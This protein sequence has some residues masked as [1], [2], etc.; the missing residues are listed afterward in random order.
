MTNLFYRNPRLLILSLALI[1]V[2]GLSSYMILPRMEDPLLTD[3]VA[4]INTIYP[5]ADAERVEALVTEKIEES[6]REIDEIKEVRSSSRTGISTI[7]IELRDNVYETAGIWSRIRDKIDDVNA[8]LP[9]GVLEPEFDQV[10]VKAFA[11]IVSLTWKQDDQPNFAILRRLSKELQDTMETIPGTQE[12]E[13]FGDPNEEVVVNLDPS[14]LASLNM[15]VQDVSRQLEAS[16]AKV[17]AGQLRGARADL[18]LEVS[19]EFDSLDRIG[20][21][22]IRHGNGSQFVQLSDIAQLDKRIQEPASSVAILDGSRG[23]A[24]GALVRS[25]YRIDHWTTDANKTLEQFAKTLPKGVELDIVFE[26]NRYVATRLFQLLVNLVLGGLA[27]AAVVFF[28]MGW[29]S[30]LVVGTALPLASLMVLAGMRFMGIPVHQM[31]VT[32]LIIALGLL[33]DN[34]IVVVDEVNARLR[35]GMKAPDAVAKSVKHLFVPLLGST[36]T[37]ALAF[38]P[39]ALMPGPAGEFVGSIAISV[40]MAIVSSFVLAMTIL[41]AITAITS[42]L[43]NTRPDN[44]WLRIWRE[45]FSTPKLTRWYRASLDFVYQRPLVG[46]GIGLVL[47]VLGAIAGFQLP[48]QFFPPADRDQIYVELELPAQSSMADTLT[49]MSQLRERLEVNDRVQ[50]V[51]WFAGESAPTFYYNVI[52]RRRNVS[53]YAQ[54]LVQLDSAVGVREV[55]HQLQAELDLAVPSGRV[56]VRQLEQGPPFD[57]PVE[58]RLYGPDI[59]RLRELGDQM[60]VLLAETP[61]VIHTRAE[62][63]ETL[64]KIAFRVDEQEARLAGFSHVEIASQLNETLEGS[65]RGSI[66]EET[67]ELPVNVRV[68]GSERR[69][70]DRIAS[71]NLLPTNRSSDGLSGKFNGVPLST[72]ATVELG[73]EIPSVPHFN[74]RRMNEVQAFITAGVLP[75]EVLGRFEERLAESD[76]KLPP[77]YS[78][79]YG[80]EA[81]KRNDAIGNLMANVGVLG[82][83]MVATLVLSFSSFRMAGIVGAVALLSVGLGVGALWI[84]GFPFGFMAIVG[85]MGL[86]G[87]AINDAIVVLAAIREDEAARIGE[88]AAVR[89]VV[90]RSSRHIVATS[91]TTMAGFMPLVI[92][93]GGF[94]PPLAV[95]IAGG[96][97]GATIIALY[98]VPS[99]YIL[100]MCKRCP[101]TRESTE[102]PAD[103]Q[104]LDHE[105]E[106]AITV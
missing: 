63:S 56:L 10:E 90:T 103:V 18:L 76:F 11:M 80:G 73:A 93:G 91:L 46:I 102:Q 21:T 36:L 25:D 95:A 75:A 38:G 37:T 84:F 100:S 64:P 17:A 35:D 101:L 98:F 69:D 74:G 99:A 8:D 19:G 33:I 67:E 92:A 83:L 97:G 51:Y 104:Q 71:L 49:K 59:Y 44:L 34:A 7:I 4:N 28:M 41:P 70:F 52:P 86:M 60:R 96:V 16:D 12:I 85:T 9:A 2:A 58:L 48:E 72:I 61:D 6:L 65:Q 94:W 53:R 1:L 55:I 106:L 29:R 5:G 22:A 31:S 39:I 14:T 57:A 79:E 105:A 20:Q 13:L 3:R 88:P 15:T 78:Y 42:R 81:A 87:V 43:S 40:I 77:G 62:L 24:V 23:I 45:G 27:V 26:Q 47:P 68:S 66:L 30:A 50:H 89:D 82:V 32:G 54:A